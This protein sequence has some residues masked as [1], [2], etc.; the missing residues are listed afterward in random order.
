MGKDIGEKVTVIRDFWRC[1]SRMV[2]AC[3]A[4]FLFTN[5][6]F[7]A[8]SSNQIDVLGDGTQC[9]TVKFSATTT[10]DATEAYFYIS[11]AGVFYIDCGDGGTLSGPGVSGQT[12]DRTGNASAGNF[13]YYR[14]SWSSAGAHTMRFSGTATAYNTNST[15]NNTSAAIAFGAYQYG[16]ANKIAS[17]SG[18][19]GALFPV[20]GTSSGEYPRFCSTFSGATNLTSIPSTLFSG[21]TYGNTGVFQQTFKNCTSLTN[22]PAG[23]FSDITTIG[24]RYVFNATF[25]NCTNLSGFIPPDT[26]AGMVANNA[27]TSV[28]GYPVFGSMFSNT[29]MATSCPSGTIPYSLGYSV[30]ND[31]VTCNCTSGYYS[32]NSTTCT[33]CSNSKPANSSFKISTAATCPWD[34]DSGYAKNG[35]NTCT[36]CS[37]NQFSANDTC[38]TNKFSLTTTSNTSYFDFKIV[39]SGTFYVNCGDGGTLHGLSGAN[40]Y[41][42][43][44]T[45]TQDSVS[46]KTYRCV[47][48]SEGVHTIKFGGAATGYT[49]GN[50]D[51]SG[52]G[53]IQFVS[54]ANVASVAGSLGAVFP[55]LGTNDGEYPM[56]KATFQ[57]CTNL[58]S[59][60][61][62][63][64]SGI[65][66]GGKGMFASTFSGCTGLTSA[67]I[68]SNLFG[69]VTTPG[70]KMFYY[71][72]GGCTGL[73]SIPDGLFST[74]T[75]GAYYMFQSTFSGCT[76]LTSIPSTLFSHITGGAGGLFYRTFQNCTG[77]TAIPPNLF[78]GINQKSGNLFDSTFDGCTS[79]SGY[80][81][82]STFAGII[83]GTSQSTSFGMWSRTFNN[84]NIATSCPTG[85]VQYITGYEFSDSGSY[86]GWGS[87]VSCECAPGYYGGEPPCNACTN[88]K[89]ANSSY[90]G[91]AATNAC[92]WSC[93]SGYVSNGTSCDTGKFSVTT[94]SDTTSFSFSMNATGTF[95]VNCGDGGTLSGT[96][97]SGEMFTR[98][99]YTITTYTCTWP[100]AGAH[101]IRFNGTATG[102]S[103]SANFG[104]LSF[105]I[106]QYG[107]AEKVASV[108]GSFSA[109][110]PQLGNSNGQYPRFY[111][112][113]SG[114]TNL[115]SISDTLFTGLTGGERMFAS[116][117]SNCVGLTS[118][119]SG[120]FKDVTTSATK[121]F[122]QT[123]YGC[124]GLTSSGI[125]AG[126]FSGITSGA[127]YMFST[128]F[129]GCTGLTSIPDG[130]F[131]TI[132]TGADYMFYKTFYS[133]TGL[134]AIPERLFSGITTA[135]T[136]MFN[137]TFSGCTN[138]SSYIP[139]S[140]FAGL[141]T[142]DHPTATG[143]WSYAFKD[144]NLLTSCP[145][146]MKQY[147]TMYEGSTTNSWN[148]K[149]SCEPCAA[150]T[151]KASSG[152][153]ACSTPDDGY[154]V[155]TTS[156]TSQTQCPVGYRS[157]SD[158]GRDEIT[159]CYVT[160]NA[161][162]TQ[163]ECSNPDT[164]GCASATCGTCSC[165]GTY[166]QYVNAAG[167]GNGTVSGSTTDSCTK[168]VASLTAKTNY[169]ANGTTSCPACTNKP[170]NSSYTAGGTTSSCPWAC[171]AGYYSADS[172]SCTAVETGYY[173]PAGSNTRTACTNGP[174]N[175]TYTGSGG[176][177][178]SCLW[179]C[180]AN[181]F[182]DNGTCSACSSLGDGSYTNSAAGA[183]ADTQC[184]KACASIAHATVTGND[185][186]GA[187]T[188]TCSF[189]CDDG[190]ADNNGVCEACPTKP[191]NSSYVNNTCT[192]SCN[193]GYELQNGECI[194]ITCNTFT[195]T[196]TNLS[197][198]ANFV[199][200]M[201]AAG[202]FIVDWGDG[203]I[204]EI[205]R[206]G[207]TTLTEYSHTYSS[208][209]VYTIGFCG[210]TTG[211]NVPASTPTAASAVISFN[212]TSKTMV[213]GIGGS[214]GALF[215]TIGNGTSGGT[216]PLFYETFKE[217]S[218]LTGP[219]PTGLFNG[220]TGSYNSMFRS[221]FDR[222][223]G[224]TELPGELFSGIT[225]GAPNL[226]RSFCYSCS[227]LTAMP[228]GLFSGI[229]NAY[230]SE[231]KFTFYQNSSMDGYIPPST[232]A[233]LIAN[234]SPT[235]SNMWSDTFTENTLLTECPEGTTE[236]NTGYKSTW[237]N[238]V[239]CEL[240][241][242]CTGATYQD[243][244]NANADENGCVACPTGYDADL[245]A[246]KTSASQCKISCAAGTYLATAN[247][248]TCT[249]VGD[250]YWAAGGL[251]A[252]GETGTRDACPD[253]RLTGKNNAASASECLVNCT[254]TNYRNANN[255]CVACP[256]GYTYNTT[257]GKT[258]AAGC[259]IQCAAGYYL[260]NANDATCS[261]V[262]HGYYTT[263][264]QV[265]NYGST[266]NR[267]QCT[268]PEETT[269]S[270]TATSESECKLYCMGATY[271]DA[272]LDD[273]IACPT[274]YTAHTNP[275]KTSATQ[276]Q[277]ACAAGTYLATTNDA[278]C[279]NVGDGY[280]AASSTV[281]Y[282]SVGTREQC[283]NGGQTGIN[284]ASNASQ[285]MGWC[286]GAQYYDSTT[287][288]CVSCPTGYNANTDD[289]KTNV[290]QCQ[291]SC[292]AGT[293]V[294]EP[295]GN[296]YTRLEYV[297]TTG[298]QYINTG[299][300][301]STLT[302][303][304]MSITMQFVTAASKKQ[305][306]AVANNYNYKFGISNGGKFLCQAAGANMEVTFANAD[307]D[308]H[309]FI[310]DT[311]NTRCSLDGEAKTL[312]VDGLSSLNAPICIGALGV[313]SGT[314]DSSRMGNVRFYEFKLM[315][316]GEL[317]MHLV[318]ARND[319]TN[320]IGMYD[321]VNGDFYP[322]TGGA[323]QT[324]QQVPAVGACVNV[325]DG[326]YA[327]ASTVNYGNYGT[328]NTCPNNTATGKENA[329][330]IYDCNNVTQCTGT[331]Y[332]NMT[333]GIC[334]S[335]P[336]GY[337]ADSTDGKDSINQCKISCS[338]GT[339]LATANDVTCT[340][341]TT[342]YW[343]SAHL[344]PYGD[345]SEPN[346]CS[347][348][349]AN[350]SYSAVGT[351]NIC[352]FTCDT[353]YELSDG[354]CVPECE[355][356]MYAGACHAYCSFGAGLFHAGEYSYPLFADRLG[357][358]SP[359][360]GAKFHDGT[361]CYGYME[362]D[363]GGEHGFKT[364][365]NNTVYHLVDPR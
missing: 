344:V 173:S 218:N 205:D 112:T 108:N 235:A 294:P 239:S 209:G 356:V 182:A 22:I 277:I 210:T 129:S 156:A 89:P 124:T 248:A 95:Y 59:V 69:S 241:N 27:P 116:T 41:V 283:P 105:G 293:Y 259:Q 60:P 21:I 244:E 98:N 242:P 179:E 362:P 255:E 226:F 33:A 102:Y 17:V 9:E 260:A 118:I 79:L 42:N 94:T 63:L 161:T 23:L 263:E 55:Q 310:L 88:T 155:A 75:T 78:S 342:G 6:A 346:T 177:T 103:T 297:E 213:A 275:G 117:F 200:K 120:L 81:P 67:G 147:I 319:T 202:N 282:G 324:S 96:G 274:G 337:N 180:S 64:F 225:G 160:A 70:Q 65:T 223:S 341:A 7:A 84:T 287:T 335:C 99:D 107:T 271:F 229:T 123:F 204:K 352:P 154:Y 318:P 336:T 162:C 308:K 355:G 224:L 184:Y 240:T 133:C 166:K 329:A 111:G 253:G 266:S 85:T 343:T 349:P 19:L 196:T 203:S 92:P 29:N 192:W 227:G 245:T 365:N 24:G 284:N 197:A 326:Y 333:T 128:T 193:P 296:G 73:T 148:G 58:T 199:F 221:T 20:L 351:N 361:V 291:T 186:Y 15:T 138:L 194:R 8:C 364:L 190:Y 347:N 247:D 134:T 353:G 261:V 306:G 91:K 44:N 330:T 217:C 288:Q 157:G 31:V 206:T 71:T 115:S 132:T 28:S 153:T 121:M 231:F 74:I 328:R 256:T 38:T 12:V 314:P 354:M 212:T 359:V 113:F 185:Y 322:P 208:G 86:P 187:G 144:T 167:T 358:S 237:N 178:N 285:C 236:F 183:T 137:Y 139:P 222:C 315:S 332:P 149:V 93:N 80:I 301:I 273:C 345:T 11:A 290:S 119:P 299:Q 249:N 37:S 360:L 1:L 312:T 280:Y 68:P 211:Y 338:A 234:K 135:A 278:T 246:E 142:H 317:V 100:S 51:S 316:N 230:D 214:L 87:R 110:L 35:N 25:E 269:D 307:T 251:V 233:G 97:V 101:T 145:A 348:K 254:G 53:A 313:A 77:I 26:F 311:E 146:G 169:Y 228:A 106:Y 90:S 126:L 10:S 32:P 175:S 321:T 304:L 50:Y 122:E 268:N 181:Y 198:G 136:Y 357:V 300:V 252:Y 14:C 170:S 83:P 219:I 265:V 82:P 54:A 243:P 250:G 47:W 295:I 164:T 109:I 325:G 159:D 76:G 188:D 57:G 48:P 171:D 298:T 158:G 363:A 195:V 16:T 151:Y 270:E 2:V 320:V 125:P 131:S 141:V 302:N 215:P 286:I 114:A 49:A 30:G 46:Y 13:D 34:C 334:T 36:A 127:E 45:I 350:S 5:A 323:L 220:V 232:F 163:N 130:L 143:M 3:V 189:E 340:A 56:F 339:Y 279:T 262:G 4:V 191:E 201:S 172:T 305:T 165:T 62:T 66:G 257:D 267:T 150:G 168:P 43:G 39:A 331:M 61:S 272:N 327:A 104:S 264:A 152:N 281:N 18:S 303:P 289:G 40:T 174:T 309:T 72:F 176:A 207:N 140:T 292:A 238:K 258:S 52:D 216:Q 276:C